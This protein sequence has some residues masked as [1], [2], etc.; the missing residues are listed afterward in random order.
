VSRQLRRSHEWMQRDLFIRRKD[1][2]ERI[3]KYGCIRE[4]QA[5]VGLIYPCVEGNVGDEISST[6]SPT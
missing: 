5:G 3:E 6:K 4:I 1:L 2:D